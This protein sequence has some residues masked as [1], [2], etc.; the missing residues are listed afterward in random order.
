MKTSL[1]LKHGVAL[2]R[3]SRWLSVML[4]K[5]FGCKLVEKL[6]AI[7]LIEAAF[8]FAN[9]QVYGVGMFNNVR[10]HGFMPEEIYSEKI[11]WQRM[12]L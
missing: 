5:M 10:K 1:A 6:R 8:N 3:L 11:E 7:L 9:K 12:D 2:K 4:E